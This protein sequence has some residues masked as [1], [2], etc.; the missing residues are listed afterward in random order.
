MDWVHLAVGEQKWRA[1]ANTVMNL[2]VLRN[3]VKLLNGW[4]ILGFLRSAVLREINYN[5][6]KTVRAS[7]EQCVFFSLY[8][9]PTCCTFFL[10]WLFIFSTCFGRLC[11]HGWLSGMQGAR[12]SSIQ[13]NKYQMSH[14]YSCFSWW[15]THSRPKHIEK[16]TKYTKKNFA[17]I[18][19]YLQDYTGMHGQHTSNC[20]CFVI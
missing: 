5:I 10:V 3:S 18:W 7:W 9:K 16:I 1:V 11:A 20:A 13:N 14:R 15:R 19:L 8:I 6:V 4:K 12:Q 2:R 17:P